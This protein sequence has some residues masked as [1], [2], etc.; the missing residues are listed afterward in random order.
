ML[1]HPARVVECAEGTRLQV[2]HDR[3]AIATV[4]GIGV[5]PL[6]SS[7]P[8]VRVSH[9]GGE[10]VITILFQCV[11]SIEQSFSVYLQCVSKGKYGT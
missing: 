4:V 1:L 5:P 9:H 3:G 6:T 10:M 2:S 8:K 11:F 7:V